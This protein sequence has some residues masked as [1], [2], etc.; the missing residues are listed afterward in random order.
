MSTEKPKGIPFASLLEPDPELPPLPPGQSGVFMQLVPNRT[1]HVLMGE[2][3][4]AD[5]AAR[6]RQG[7]A[8]ELLKSRGVSRERAAA[9]EKQ[10]AVTKRALAPLRAGGKTGRQN[11]ATESV[12]AHIRALMAT[13]PKLVKSP[14]Q[15]YKKADPTIIGDMAQKTFENHVRACAKK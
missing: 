3:D 2:K 11:K 5:K 14:P 8:N 9:A 10:V 1:L 12:R 4:A 6:V 15:L 7:V 13:H